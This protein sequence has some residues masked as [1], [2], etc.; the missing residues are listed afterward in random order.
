[1]NSVLLP[2]FTN[3]LSSPLPSTVPVHPTKNSFVHSSSV[4]LKEFVSSRQKEKEQ[5]DLLPKIA[6]LVSF[7]N[8]GTTYT[9]ANTEHMSNFSTATN[10]EPEVVADIVVPILPKTG[11]A[12]F[13]F[14]S[15][16]RLPRYVLTKTHCTG[17]SD[18]WHS[19]RVTHSSETFEPSCR[20]ATVIRECGRVETMEYSR[21]LLAKI[22]HI[23]RN[24]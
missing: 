23:M 8:S 4:V 17:Y 16:L 24:P 5:Q 21:A 13:V 15:E 18:R 22:V 19:R 3:T 20:R 2:V 9:I 1:M 14:S 12:P 10:Y 6:L 7:P 11:G